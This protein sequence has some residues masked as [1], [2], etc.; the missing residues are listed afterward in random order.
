MMSKILFGAIL[1]DE[2]L[3]VDVFLEGGDG[4]GEAR[5]VVKS[6]EEADHARETDAVIESVV[7]AEGE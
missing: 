4:R 2:G 6:L 5:L 1:G 3:M 7:K